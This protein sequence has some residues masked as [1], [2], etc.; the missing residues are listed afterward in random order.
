MPYAPKMR[1]MSFNPSPLSYTNRM[2]LHAQLDEY[3]Q[4]HRQLWAGHFPDLCEQY[5]CHPVDMRSALK[6]Y[7][8]ARYLKEHGHR[9]GY[10]PYVR[11][12]PVCDPI[13]DN[14]KPFGGWHFG[15]TDNP[16]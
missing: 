4:D 6:L 8:D 2:K 15:H 14:I 16:A 5:R 3:Y 7:R 11:R 10:K 12:T 13:W 9:R 1:P